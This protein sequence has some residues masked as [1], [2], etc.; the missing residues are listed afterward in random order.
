MRDTETPSL[1]D[2]Q[3]F[4]LIVRELNSAP[5][6]AVITNRVAN[7]GQVVSFPVVA[8]DN[9]LP[10]QIIDIQFSSLMSLLEPRLIR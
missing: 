6:L 4:A 9:D 8:S 10:S 1:S 2:T 7:E 5:L 3:S